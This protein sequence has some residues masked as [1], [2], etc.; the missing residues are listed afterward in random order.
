MD[1]FGRVNNN[2]FLQHFRTARISRHARLGMDPPGST[3]DDWG[4]IPAATT[5][6]YRSAGRA[7]GCSARENSCARGQQTAAS[8]ASEQTRVKPEMN[9]KPSSAQLRLA[10]G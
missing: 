5:Y 6:R 3:R 10:L 4:P 1:P 2:V 7:P 8:P 9:H